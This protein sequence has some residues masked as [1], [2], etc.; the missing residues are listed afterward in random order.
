MTVTVQKWGNSQGIR[1]PKHILD[2]VDCSIGTE[3]DV[4]VKDGVIVLKK[5]DAPLKIDLKK[6]FEEY[7]GE[8]PTGEIDWGRPEGEEVW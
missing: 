8:I 1:I 7:K 3:F 5:A 2:E 4:N 6:A